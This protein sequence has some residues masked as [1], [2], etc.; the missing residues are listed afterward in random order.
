MSPR[1]NFLA[2]PR[3]LQNQKIRRRSMEDMT[4]PSSPCFRARPGYCAPNS[5]RGRSWPRRA[6]P[7]ATPQLLCAESGDGRGAQET[8]LIS[9]TFHCYSGRLGVG[10]GSPA[11]VRA[12]TLCGWSHPAATAVRGAHKSPLKNTRGKPRRA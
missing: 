7:A 2:N 9:E 8:D 3:E 6:A 12:R 11:T 1:A 4:V 5:R 10:S